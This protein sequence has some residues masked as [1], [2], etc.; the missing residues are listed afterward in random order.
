MRRPLCRFLAT[1]GIL[2][3]IMQQRAQ[4]GISRR[5]TLVVLCKVLNDATH[6]PAL[7]SV[8]CSSGTMQVNGALGAHGERALPFQP[9]E[10]F[11]GLV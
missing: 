7:Y 1:K 4:L 10:F 8:Q 9:P 5:V 6:S 2:R 11:L 3:K